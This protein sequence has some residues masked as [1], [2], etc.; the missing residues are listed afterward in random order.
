MER[1]PGERDPQNHGERPEETNPKP[2][3]A[4]GAAADP[5]AIAQIPIRGESRPRSGIWMDPNII[6]RV[7]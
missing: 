7:S 2:G 6:M 1:G 4:R 5:D 3:C